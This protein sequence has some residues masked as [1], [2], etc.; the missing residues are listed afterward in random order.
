MA[1]ISL[2]TVQ[3]TIQL[4]KDI[5]VLFAPQ[6]PYLPFYTAIGGALVGALSSIFP[7]F[8]SSW[9]KDKR[10]RKAMSLQLY[11]EVKAILEVAEARQYANA[12]RQ[13]V[14]S[15]K[16]GQI[17]DRIYQI[18]LPD[19]RFPVYKNSL[20]NLGLLSVDLQVPIVS[21]YQT[22]EAIIQDIKPGGVLNDTPVGLAEFSEV[23][24][25]LE[26]AEELG[27]E[28]VNLIECEYLIK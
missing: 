22:L 25:L 13:I 12:L 28:I 27:A 26:K 18:Q 17:S 5:K 16:S 1:D 4:I 11:A 6:D 19:D 23:L 9:I 15:L 7:S 21:F 2:E 8:I 14:S 3:S 10:D 20:S 24:A